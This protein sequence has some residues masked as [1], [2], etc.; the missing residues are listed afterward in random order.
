LVVVKKLVTNGFYQKVK[1]YQAKLRLMP[2]D[3]NYEMI[4]TQNRIK[5]PD[6]KIILPLVTS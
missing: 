4:M 6:K 2:S 1:H 5:E 3:K